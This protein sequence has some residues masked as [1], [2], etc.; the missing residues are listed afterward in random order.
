MINKWKVTT[1][2][3]S[4]KTWGMTQ[5]QMRERVFTRVL[6]HLWDHVALSTGYRGSEPI[7]VIRE[8]LRKNYNGNV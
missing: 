5:D 4:E 1:T 3:E 2:L 8:E 7:H 6:S